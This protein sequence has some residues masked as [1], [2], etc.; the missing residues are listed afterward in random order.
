MAA[1]KRVLDDGASS[2]KSKK[3]KVGQESVNTDEPAQAT[4]SLTMDEIDFPRGGGTTLTPLEVKSI[5]AE[6]AREADAELFAAPKSKRPRKKN[7]KEKKLDPAQKRDVARVE[8]LNYKR[9]TPGM[10]ILGRIHSVRPLALIVSLPNQLMAHVPITQVTSQFTRHLESMDENEDEDEEE[11][12]G[13]EAKNETP[14]LHDLF[15][16][17]QFVRAVVTNVYA[18]GVSEVSGLGRVRDDIAKASKRVELSL[19]PEDVNAGVQKSDLQ[20][21]FTLTAAVKSVEDHGYLLD[22]GVPDV[23]GFMSFQD[24]QKGRFGDKKLPIGGLLDVAVLKKSGNG[25]TCT[26]SLDAQLFATSSLSEVTN[27]SSI[28]PGT[29]VQS[30]ITAISPEGINVQVLGFFDGTVDDAHLP[31][32]TKFKV[33]QKVKCRVLYAIPA[34]SPPKLVLA[35]SDH[36]I[37]L[38]S[39]DAE[40]EQLQSSYPIGTILDD[41]KVAKVEGER[42]LTVAVQPGL[43]GFIHISQ[44]AD[45]RVPSLSASSGPWR[46]GTLHRARVIGHHI[47][48]RVLQLSS[49]P[50]VLEQKFVQAGDIAVGEV[51]KGSVKKLTETALFISISGNAD[52]VIWPNHYADIALKHPSKRFKPGGSVK[53]RVLTVDPERKRVVLTAKKTLVDSELPIISSFEDAKVGMVVHAV[54]FKVFEKGLQLEFFNNVKAFVPVREAS[55]GTG[56]LTDAFPVGKVVKVRIINIDTDTSRIVASVRQA[57]SSFKATAG[58][59]SQ[60]EVGNEVSGTIAELH[61]LNAVVSLK[62]IDVRALVSLK[63]LASSRNT[64]VAQLKG[65]VAIGDEVH[66]LVIVSRNSEKGFVIA[67]CKPKSKTASHKIGPL[68]METVAPGQVVG[69]RVLRQG[70]RGAIVKLTPKISGFLHPTDSCDN[71]ETGTPFPPKDSVLKATVIEVDKENN[72]LDLSM[73]PSRLSG[74]V[75]SVVDRE[76]NSFEDIKR[77]DTLRG[78]VKSVADHGLFV[79]LGRHVD[80]RVQIKEL[81][82]EYVKDWK[83]RFK[84][85]QLVKGRILSVDPE[86]KKVEMTFRSGDLNRNATNGLTLNDLHEGQKVKGR[87][88]R[89]EAYGLFIEVEGSK[90]SGLCHKSELSDNKDADVDVALRTFREGDTV[91]AMIKS[92][93]VSKRKISFG[94]KPSYFSAED[95]DDESG[96]SDGAADSPALGVVEQDDDEQMVDPEDAGPEDSDGNEEDGAGE[97]EDSESEG[98]QMDIDLAPP[99]ISQNVGRN[100]QPVPSASLKLDGFNWFNG[101]NANGVDDESSNSEDSDSDGGEE[102]KKKRKKKQ[103]IQQDLTAEMHTKAPESNAD[104]ERLLLGSPNSSYLWIQYMSF[105]LKLSEVEKAREIARRAIETIGFREEQEK[106]NVCIA[107][108]NLENTYGT[109]ESLENAFKDAARRNDSKTVHLQLA[110]IFDQSEKHE[111]AEEQYKRTCKKFGQSSKVWSLFCEY[112][113][114]RGEVEQARKLLP[115]SLQSLEKRKHLKTISKFAQLEYKLGDPERGKT[116]YEGIVDSHPKRWDLWSVYM[117]M[118]AGQQNIQSLRN[119]FER[120][121][122]HKMTSRKA[123]YFFKKWLDYERRFGDEEGAD[124]VKSKAVEWTQAALGNSAE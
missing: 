45:D 110:S 44:T 69:G 47:F 51:M 62:P 91:Q 68:S 13:A 18:P 95:V 76:I 59:V 121:L 10:K 38:V 77:G 108:L 37:S 81:F 11:E 36:I 103:V 46:C 40:N 53:C 93:D 87:I 106:L 117:D 48:D 17:G 96:A 99:S 60:V 80:A 32:G 54:V 71:Y 86:N 34:S 9:L 57:A 63:N 33:G 24:A 16:P 85:N 84:A 19:V 21:G 23:S 79:M 83:P 29:L 50:S 25:R 116:I 114:K 39:Q 119:I 124:N 65:T 6:G 105:Q 14:E 8:H 55:E 22:L 112:Y 122:T 97:E 94:L 61:K 89:I 66:E 111:K 102:R 82:D 70:L 26:V 43:A 67:A 100:A 120:V 49:K 74:D 3:P 78:F 101:A 52:G 1:K 27:V 98:D 41:V 123:K 107:L 113:L 115:R 58:D 72:Q 64:T 42:G 56:T 104:F 5:R 7:D 109:D 15:Y 20:L 2:Q 4:S 35:L 30:L 90:I 31:S 75:S 28:L 118:E 12:E 73:R 92:I 88:K